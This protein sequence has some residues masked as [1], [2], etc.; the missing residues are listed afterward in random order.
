MD[1]ESYRGKRRETGKLP[2]NKR[3]LME[4]AAIELSKLKGHNAQLQQEVEAL[5]EQ[6]QLNQQH[7][8]D[9]YTNGF[10][11]TGEHIYIVYWN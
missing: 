9:P 2:S 8:H 6:L 10:L 5:Q 4:Q 7:L 3:Q 1:Q 11:S